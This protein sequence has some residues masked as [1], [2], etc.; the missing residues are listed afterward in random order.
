MK[1]IIYG[2]QYG[3]ARKY[4]EEL[5]RTSEIP[6]MSYESVE[7]INL[8][9]TIVYIG[10]LYAGGVQGMKKTLGKYHSNDSKKLIIATVG[11]ADP[12]DVENTDN[13]KSSLKKQLSADV[14]DKA[15][16]Y[17]LR[18]GI[19]YSK[20]NFKHKTMM[21][22]LYKKAK[23]LP[24]EEKNAEVR[25]MIDTYNQAVDF[26]DFKRLDPIINELK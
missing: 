9:D 19:D 4:A 6:C 7:D 1:M 25:A 3:T 13:I 17:H 23:G 22:L 16:I 26:V 5:S 18:G 20:L 14:F 15:S 12:D 21:G 2:T 8:F 11:L 10:S 24:E